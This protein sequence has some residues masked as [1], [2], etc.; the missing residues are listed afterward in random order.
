MSLIRLL[1]LSFGL[2]VLWAGAGL[3]EASREVCWSGWGYRVELDTL[4]FKSDRLLLVTGGP[5]DWHPGT[6]VTLYPLDPAS[7]QRDPDAEPLTIKV[8]QPTFRSAKGN[9]TVDDVADLIGSPFHLM[10]GMTRIGPA[11]VADQRQND[12]LAWACGRARN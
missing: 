5:V 7:G 9:R 1:I 8:R 4:A 6:R 11:M 12:F 10:L 3:A 2:L